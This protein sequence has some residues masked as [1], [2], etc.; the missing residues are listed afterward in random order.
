LFADK[1]LVAINPVHPKIKRILVQTMD[2]KE[3]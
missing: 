3:I 2:I 1:S